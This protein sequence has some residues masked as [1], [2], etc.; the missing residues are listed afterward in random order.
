MG[1]ILTNGAWVEH[2][3]RVYAHMCGDQ[4]PEYVFKETVNNSIR[5]FPSI[6]MGVIRLFPRIFPL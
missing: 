5:P 1:A 4:E 6:H 3:T 2:G